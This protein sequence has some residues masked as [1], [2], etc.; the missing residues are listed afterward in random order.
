MEEVISFDIYNSVKTL[1]VVIYCLYA[2]SFVFGISATIAIII[3]YVKKPDV[4]GTYIDRMSFQMA[5]LEHSGSIFS[6][7]L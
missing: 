6:G 1:T 4:K 2:L 3:N 5:G 7:A